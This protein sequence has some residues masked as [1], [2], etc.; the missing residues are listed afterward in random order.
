MSVCD[1]Y[2]YTIQCTTNFRGKCDTN[3]TWHKTKPWKTGSRQKINAQ[4]RWVNKIPLTTG[5]LKVYVRPEHLT[6]YVCSETINTLPTF[7]AKYWEKIVKTLRYWLFEKEIW[8][9][10]DW[11]SGQN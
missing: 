2:L 11:V 10:H 5:F 6:V 9:L 1:Q 3:L 7:P 4:T 8:Y